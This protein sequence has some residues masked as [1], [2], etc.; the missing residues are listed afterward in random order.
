[1]FYCCNTYFKISCNKFLTSNFESIWLP[2]GFQ[3]IPLV[4][5]FIKM[6]IQKL[7]FY[8][9]SHLL[10]SHWRWLI[11]QLKLRKAI[12]RNKCR[13][14]MALLAASFMSWGYIPLSHFCKYPGHTTWKHTTFANQGQDIYK[15][16]IKGYMTE[17]WMC[18]LR[19]YFKYVDVTHIEQH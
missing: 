10:F 19:V 1:M 5:N 15:S 8:D 16:V 9:V 3:K 18:R 17:L 12:R 6:S 7:R 14:I 13:K 4:L 2:L 11:A